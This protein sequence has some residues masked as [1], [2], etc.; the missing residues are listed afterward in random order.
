MTATAD[1]RPL[2]PP[3]A[4]RLTV[5]MVVPVHNEAAILEQQVTGLRPATTPP[6]GLANV[7]S[8]E[9]RRLHDF[10]PHP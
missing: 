1:A 7:T 5:D 6:P 2:P 8:A 9:N 10:H 3:A 4:G